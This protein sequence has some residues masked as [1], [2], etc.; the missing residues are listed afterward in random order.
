M[1]DKHEE[2]EEEQAG[3]DR[4]MYAPVNEPKNNKRPIHKVS[5]SPS[6]LHC[7]RHIRRLKVNSEIHNNDGKGESVKT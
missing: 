7:C 5:E 2:E 1:I 3:P 6:P 4:C